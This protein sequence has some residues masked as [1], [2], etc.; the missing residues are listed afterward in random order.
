MIVFQNPGEI[1][2]EAL[3]TLGFSDKKPDSFGRFGTGGKYGIAVA[4]RGGA[5]IRIISGTTCHVIGST[6]KVIAGKPVDI[7]C[8]DGRPTSIT[9]MFGRDWE[10]WMV[11]REFACNARD[12]GGSFWQDGEDG[13]KP[14]GDMSDDDLAGQTTIVIDWPA[15]DE[16]YAARGSLFVEGEPIWQ[17]STVRILPG[18]SDFLFYQGVRVHKLQT[19]S[20]M[21]YDL[22]SYMILSE[23]RTLVLP[24]MAHTVIKRAILKQESQELLER[25]LTGTRHHE[26]SYDYATTG[27]SPSRDFLAVTSSARDSGDRPLNKSARDLLMR[28]MRDAMGEESTSMVYRA[29]AYERGE[30][31]FAIERLREMGIAFADDQQFIKVD[32]LPGGKNSMIEA[33]R[34]FFR[35]TIFGMTPDDL[36]MELLHRWIELQPVYGIEDTAELLGGLMVEHN[37]E[38]A[39]A[40]AFRAEHA[41]AASLP[42]P[43]VERI[44]PKADV[45]MTF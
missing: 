23:D 44:T 39:Q 29:I 27:G 21:T 32:E 45:D 36:C 11:L 1:D 8:I 42:H 25:V 19:P 6:P 34:L 10:P 40:R 33:R 30:W 16:A 4:L 20:A 28:S 12:E 3:T 31:A 26:A 7:I 22:L 18:P 37:V 17:D 9:T 41:T 2:V 15:L 14:F 43:P 24:E 13:R 35:E 5:H 38:L